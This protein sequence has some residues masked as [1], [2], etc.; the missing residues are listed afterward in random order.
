MVVTR[1]LCCLQFDSG[2]DKFCV[3]F[4]LIV[5]VTRVLCCLQFDSGGDKSFV[6]PSS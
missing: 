3:A 1:V 2:G 6:L 4:N 5:V